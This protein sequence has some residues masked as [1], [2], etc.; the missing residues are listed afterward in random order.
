MMVAILLAAMVAA[1]SMGNDPVEPF[2][3]VGNVHYVGASDVTAFLAL[4]RAL[5][6]RVQ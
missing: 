3:I 5:E 2:R 4:E 1:S 6:E